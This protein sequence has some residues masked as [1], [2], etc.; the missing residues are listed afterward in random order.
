MWLGV[1]R[2]QR[3]GTTGPTPAIEAA[4]D[5]GNLAGAVAA[6]RALEGDAAAAALP[7]LTQAEAR[8]AIEGALVTLADALARAEETAG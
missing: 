6:T 2:V 1:I 4:L 5:A 3:E 7:W 8:L